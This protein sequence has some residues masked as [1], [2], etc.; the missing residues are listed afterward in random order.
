MLLI[1]IDNV[2]QLEFTIF[3]MISSNV[4]WRLISFEI[5]I[6]AADPTD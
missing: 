2:N 6:Q 5:W 3:E 1:D 4:G